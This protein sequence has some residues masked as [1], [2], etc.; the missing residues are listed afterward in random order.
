MDRTIEPGGDVDV[1]DPC[2][3][4]P[5]RVVQGQLRTDC[6]VRGAGVT[7]LAGPTSEWRAP[8]SYGAP[9]R[10]TTSS[11]VGHGGPARSM[12]S[13]LRPWV[14]PFGNFQKPWRSA[15]RRPTMAYRS[16]GPLPPH[17][18][19]LPLTVTSDGDAVVVVT[20]VVVVVDVVI[21]AT[22]VDEQPASSPMATRQ[23]AAT[24]RPRVFG[25]WSSWDSVDL[26]RGTELV[27]PMLDRPRLQV[28]K[29][30]LEPIGASRNRRYLD[31]HRDDVTGVPTRCRVLQIGREDS[32]VLASG[33]RGRKVEG[34]PTEPAGHRFTA[35][36][37]RG[38]TT[39][40]GMM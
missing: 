34:R 6:A 28:R 27:V 17:I 7:D 13:N 9:T 31:L 12:L 15:P 39:S 3:G 32:G 38:T 8:G 20:D 21:I 22:D 19:A 33:V 25:R 1:V 2:V 11:I 30:K 24:A 23:T 36:D 4:Y 14:I 37:A 18:S 40:A 35:H 26:H 16:Q 5:A 10:P 29:P